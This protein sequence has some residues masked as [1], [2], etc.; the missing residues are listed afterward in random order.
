[1]KWIIS[2]SLFVFSFTAQASGLELLT[3][4]TLAEAADS[5]GKTK[6]WAL[7]VAIVNQEGNLVYFQRGDHAYSG[8]IDAAIAKAK[9]AG[10]FQRPTSA[11]V[12]GIKDGRHGLL[13]VPG[14]VAIEG[15]LPITIN[16][17]I[18]GA[19]GVSG[20]KSLED[21]EAATVALKSLKNL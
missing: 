19:I 15:G 6:N 17:R 2:V 13:S 16:G 14:V 20:A 11:F 1:M 4:K 7:S 9:S 5:Y 3:A 18:V 10:A 21:E 12:Q 8:S